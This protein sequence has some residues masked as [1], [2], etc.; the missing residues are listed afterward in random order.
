MF[1]RFSSRA[2]PPSPETLRPDLYP[3]VPP[4]KE[5]DWNTRIA[6]NKQL[7]SV[8][9]PFHKLLDDLRFLT[10][11]QRDDEGSGYLVGYRMRKN[12]IIAGTVSRRS[13]RSP[14]RGCYRRSGLI[15]P[16]DISANCARRIS[17]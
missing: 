4:V 6:R 3:P 12:A 5:E 16:N 17:I 11:V 10:V 14:F 1:K 13:T 15:R 9:E 2:A 8:G 7:N